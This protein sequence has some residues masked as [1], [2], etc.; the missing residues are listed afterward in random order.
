MRLS[1]REHLIPGLRPGER[2][3]G[4]RLQTGGVGAELR[5][6]ITH[7]FAP[8]PM[9]AHGREQRAV[10]HVGPGAFAY[11]LRTDDGR[12]HL[13]PDN[14]RTRAVDGLQSSLLVVDGT[15]EPVV[16][17]PA[18]PY[19]HGAED[20]RL[21][22]RAALRKGA[23]GGSLALR[24]LDAD[25]PREV[26][27]RR[28]GEEDE[29]LL[30]EALVPAQAKRLD[31]LFVLESGRGIGRGGAAL[32]IE[33]HELVQA[34]PEWWRD[35]VLYTV[36]LDRFRDGSG[37]T[38][39]L[40]VDERARAGGDLWGVRDAIPYLAEL[41]VTVLHLTPVAYS[42]SAH[43]YDAINPL[44]V[45]PALGGEPALRAVI[46]AAHRHGLRV[47]LDVVL[48]HVHRDF[49]P[50]CDVRQR[51][52]RS[53]YAAWF[54]PLRYPFS[55][56]EDP[57]YRHYQKGQWQEPL[58]A[59]DPQ[60]ANEDVAAYLVQVLLHYL[61]LGVDGFRL[62]AAADVPLGLLRLLRAAVRGVRKDALLLG[63]VTVDSLFR[64]TESALDCATDFPLQEA[65]YDWLWRR[66][67]D[68]RRLAEVHARRRFYRGAAQ[69]GL[70]FT[71]TH[72]QPRLLSLVAEARVARLG[73]LIT[74]L[75]PEVPAVLYGDEIGLRGAP[76]AGRVAPDEPR[77][78]RAF[79]DAW[80]DRAPM[81]WDEQRWDQDTHALFRDALRLR[82]EHVALRR[83]AYEPLVFDGAPQLLGFRRRSAGEIIEVYAH[84]G[85][86]SCALALPADAPSDAT[87]LL[88][89][90][91]ARLG[92][93]D[94]AGWTAELGPF[95][96]LVVSRHA[97]PRVEATRRALLAD[98][99]ATCAQAF[100]RGA[101][102]APSLPSHLYVTVTE[103]CNLRCQHCI[104]DAPLRTREGRARTL[105][106]FVL[107]ALDEAFA[108]ADYVA[109]AHGGE[110]LAADVFWEVLERLG[111]AR[112]GRAT[113]V[114]L[115]T[116][117]MLLS[118]KTV[119]AL[120]DYGVT[121]LAVSIDGATAATNDSIRTGAELGRILDN[122]HRALHIRRERGADLRIGL[123]SVVTRGN[124]GELGALGQLAADLGVDWLKVEELYV[125]NGFTSRE[126]IPPQHLRVREGMTAL[127]SA[128]EPAGV[129]VVDHLSARPG[130]GC[131][132]AAERASD[133]ALSEFRTAD[134]FANRT[135]FHPCRAAWEQACI[136]PDGTVHPVS[137]GHPPLGSLADASLFELWHGEAMQR[138]RTEALGRIDAIDPTL[139]RR[140]S[141]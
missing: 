100:A 101:L 12:W 15:D 10:V 63:E 68:A 5:G 107:D 129:V 19:L 23:A 67:G 114:H 103:R 31:Y 13:D 6:E 35:A 91:E 77:A 104:T 133:L 37:R 139:R 82:R 79:E 115:L 33:P 32:R 90:G 1:I 74:L 138:L 136:D 84:G 21:C 14:P 40:P 17:A 2:A 96:A 36:F 25:G 4:F 73:H 57:G 71:A 106:P 85:E 8:I 116:N 80:P 88:T 38:L 61:S 28:V 126:L 34:L 128:A 122:V 62:D 92:G 24:L 118:E 9:Q 119:H 52:P 112:G 124:V 110:S 89:L 108:A 27:M 42:H 78:L 102:T 111:R 41:G 83:G 49:L 105:Q 94:R 97:P 130:I 30:F 43:R 135:C 53:P 45:D 39:P 54:Q 125:M 132:C 131:L 121:S 50:F 66:R 22:V 60:S 93:D 109:F 98:N 123:S 46:E 141:R 7:W 127:R 72:D 16:H 55:E 69:S 47:L 75:G 48:T 140:C 29:H 26:P 87:V 11:K 120:I 59:L 56:G 137:Y 70:A 86:G 3:V 58:L 20:G 64:F 51:G 113:D 65:L 44:H 81:P 76:G 95:S 134:D 117:G 18:V 99:A